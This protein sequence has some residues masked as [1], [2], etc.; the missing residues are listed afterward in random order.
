MRPLLRRSINAN[1]R[2]GTDEALQNLLDYAKKQDCPAAMRAEAIAALSTWAKP[3]VVDRVDGRY[4]GVIERDLAKVR[5]QAG[6]TLVELL[7]SSDAVVRTSAVKAVNKLGITE[8]SAKL[9]TLLKSDPQADVRVEA[10]K[11]MASTQ[12]NRMDEAIKLAMTDREKN[13]RITAI[14]LID[15][16]NIPKQ[17]MADLL[18]DVIK[19]RTTEEKQASLTTLGKL[20][21][22]NTEK[23]LDG[24]LQQMAAGKLPPDINLELEEAIDSSGSSALIK[25]YQDI[26]GSLS[27][28]ALLA[29]YTGSLYG[30]DRD[31]GAQIFFRN[32]TAQCLRCHSFYDFG[33]TAG[34]RLNGVASRISREQILQALISPSARLAP[35]FGIVT[36]ELKNGKSISGGPGKRRQYKPDG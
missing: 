13:V 24:L 33:G 7:N 11:A 22:V 26:S 20:P 25:R 3:S 36:L 15:K 2:V 16:L 32:E 31:R 8:G 12:D 14:S 21:L 10:L 27:K 29:S 17:L 34:P 6:A 30:G 9:L 4:R 5:G 18:S 23:V 28:D 35:G 19:T 1:L